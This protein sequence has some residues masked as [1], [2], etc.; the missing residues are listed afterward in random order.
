MRQGQPGLSLAQSGWYQKRFIPQEVPS[1]L[2][3]CSLGGRYL[4]ADLRTL[5]S[6]SSTGTA[7]RELS[8][9]LLHAL[10]RGSGR[11]VITRGGG[12]EK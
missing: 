5:D 8:L 7:S 1:V 9:S 11:R 10:G 6:Y 12:G 4:L 3:L 2:P